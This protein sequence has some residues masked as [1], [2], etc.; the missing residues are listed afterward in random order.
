MP[1]TAKIG[2]NSKWPKKE[3]N[4]KWPKK[5]KNS[6]NHKKQSKTAKKSKTTAK[7]DQNG[8]N[9]LNWPRR[10]K[11]FKMAKKAHN[12]QVLINVFVAFWA[13]T[14]L[15]TFRDLCIEIGTQFFMNQRPG[16]SLQRKQGPFATKIGTQNDKQGRKLTNVYKYGP[17]FYEIV[18]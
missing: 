13:G 7:I 11:Q 8:K 2:Q 3:K 10:P 12:G 18:T 5:E 17:N 9:S 4:S 15:K 14:V 6:P 1:K 16:H